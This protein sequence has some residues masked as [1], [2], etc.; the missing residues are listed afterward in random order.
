MQFEYRCTELTV[1]AGD[2]YEARINTG[3]ERLMKIQLADYS[4]PTKKAVNINEAYA[5]ELLKKH[6]TEVMDYYSNRLLVVVKKSITGDF[7]LGDVLFGVGERSMAEYLLSEGF[8]RPYNGSKYAPWPSE[9]LDTII[10]KL[11]V[12]NGEDRQQVAF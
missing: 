1:L 2:V 3:T 5:A 12:Y 10:S 4:A 11:Q 7:A 8:I 9:V 6:V